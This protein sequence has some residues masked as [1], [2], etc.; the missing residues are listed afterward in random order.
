MK[1]RVVVQEP[2]FILEGWNGYSTESEKVV[3]TWDDLKSAQVGTVWEA[4]DRSS[5]VRDS[6]S[7]EAKVVY[8]DE[9]GAAVLHINK[10]TTDDPY[11][12]EDVIEFMLVWYEWGSAKIPNVVTR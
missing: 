1:T 7:Q 8:K 2:A 9:Y 11:Q 5:C 12:P 4:Q 10:K 6:H 3:V